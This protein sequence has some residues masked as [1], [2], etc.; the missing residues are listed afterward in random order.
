MKTFRQQK[1]YSILLTFVINR[2]LSFLRIKLKGYGNKNQ[3]VLLLC[4]K[5]NSNLIKKLN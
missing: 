4:K 5:K 2:I 1:P 3:N